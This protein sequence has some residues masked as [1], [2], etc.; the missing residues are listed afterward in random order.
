MASRIGLAALVARFPDFDRGLVEGIWE[1]CDGCEGECVTQLKSFGAKD[2]SVT[3]AAA[4][5]AAPPPAASLS[6]GPASTAPP[7]GMGS[8]ETSESGSASAGQV[9]R[10]P[11]SDVFTGGGAW[12]YDMDAALASGE[13]KVAIEQR[14]RNEEMMHHRMKDIQLAFKADREFDAA[15][16]AQRKLG[17]QSARGYTLN[18][19][20]VCGSTPHAE[21]CFKA[22]LENERKHCGEFVCFY[23]SY[24]FAALIYEVQSC[25]S[26]VVYGLP[27][28][29]APMPRLHKAP[30]KGKP[31][32][33]ALVDSFKSMSGQDHNPS[34]REVAISVSM[35]LGSPSS[36]APPMQCFVNG[37][38]CTDLS[39]HGVL[40]SMLTGLGASTAEADT[41]IRAADALSSK[42]G[43]V[44][45]YSVP[46]EHGMSSRGGHLPGHML[47]I[48]VRSDCV[49]DVA[50]GSHAYGVW[51]DD[52]NPLSSYM[53]QPKAPDGQA[54]VFWHPSLFTDPKRTRVYHFAAD[55][56]ASSK[57]AEL[58]KGLAEILRPL[59]GDAR[60]VVKT[61]R[62]V[63]GQSLEHDAPPSA[64]AVGTA[65]P[66]A[67]EE[68][69]Y[70]DRPRSYPTKTKGKVSKK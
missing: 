49:D 3:A 60:A 24:S 45:N 42:C 56:L 65:A 68:P 25:L 29:F 26:R 64:A 34:F 12:T 4:S 44:G 50:Y 18:F 70:M 48:F 38:S 63:E 40:Q 30:F 17:P 6:A 10:Q 47:Q 37:Y 54:R 31:H 23:H 62:F 69:I 1:A 35:S 2:V 9:S 52:A 43:L 22:M 36:E 51:R 53:L 15:V 32:V 8:P 55:P 11:T 7:L 57:R 67:A 5:A 27:D 46:G 61:F 16:A 19:S 13:E 21:K 20:S 66:V 28:D 39:F 41:M 14:V 58:Q 33:K 59:L